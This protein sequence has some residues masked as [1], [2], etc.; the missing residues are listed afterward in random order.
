MVGKPYSIELD[1]FQ[2]SLNWAF[3]QDISVLQ[4]LLLSWAAK[5]VSIVGSGGSHS[6]AYLMSELRKLAHQTPTS[7]E[8]PLEYISHAKYTSLTR[9]ILLSAEGK[10]ADII[11]AAK[12]AQ[13]YDA[14]CVAITL[15]TDNPL[16]VL[17]STEGSVKLIPFQMDWGKDGYLATNTQ[18]AT[19]FLFYKA[20]FDSKEAETLLRD[21]LSE[22]QLNNYRYTWLNSGIFTRLLRQQPILVLHDALTK[23]FAIDFESKA[24][25]AALA[26]V[27]ICDYRQ[28]A[29][30][31]H[32]QLASLANAPVIVSIY[33]E[34]STSLYEATTKLIPEN[35]QKFSFKV[36]GVKPQ[37]VIFNSLLMASYAIEALALSIN[38]D[39]GQ[40]EV[41]EFGRRLHKL[42]YL[43]SILPQ[44][45]SNVVDVA[46]KRKSDLSVL[47][48]QPPAVFVESANDFCKELSKATIK[49]IVSDFDGTL[50]N[51]ES[52]YIGMCPRVGEE[53]S[54]LLNEGIRLIIASG[55][56]D[57]LRKCLLD[58]ID[59]SFHEKVL[60]GYYGGSV[61]L[62]LSI[63]PATPSPNPEF[64]ELLNWLGETY[65]DFTDP[66]VK[67]AKGGQFTIRTNSSR[68]STHLASALRAWVVENKKVGWRVFSSGH[69]LDVLDNDTSKRNVLRHIHDLYNLDLTSEILRLGD[70]GHEDGNDYE[71]LSNGLSLSSDRISSS[72]ATCWNFA[73]KGNRQA[74]ATLYY[75]KR[76]VPG[77]EGHRFIDFTNSP[78]SE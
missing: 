58:A 22:T 52:R 74:N 31:R 18:V 5:S 33:S 57:S 60:V 26:S 6:V 17:G 39:P 8:T 20:L 13:E 16:A 55:R 76:L 14:E 71:L 46:A 42:S 3:K 28:F 62:P 64:H 12:T 77:P 56:G 24:S 67:Y 38:V 48:D 9:S 47:T 40:P 32:L 30:G 73:P 1:Q 29:H 61:I 59:K 44:S 15:T 66:L 45:H 68:V 21:F 51:T 41:P 2:H 11:A 35:I 7:Y 65:T 36:S 72:L 25:E 37:H 50:C 78:L 75:L 43:K 10:N 53:L 49:A 27:Q 4:Q 63:D 23:S 54:R 69:S 70:S 19:S 34:S